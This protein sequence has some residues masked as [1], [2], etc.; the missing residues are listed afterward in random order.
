MTRTEYLSAELYQKN[1]LR[2]TKLKPLDCSELFDDAGVEEEELIMA[3]LKEVAH[4]NPQSSIK[5]ISRGTR[6]KN[7][8]QILHIA[9]LASYSP[10][11]IPHRSHHPLILF[12]IF[13]AGYHSKLSFILDIIGGFYFWIESSVLAQAKSA[14][15]LIFWFWLLA[16]SASSLVFRVFLCYCFFRPTHLFAC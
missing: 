3:R 9:L 8:R 5:K 11:G 1:L 4:E 10:I 14:F 6:S 16:I 2:L 12:A 7:N 13:V 15:I